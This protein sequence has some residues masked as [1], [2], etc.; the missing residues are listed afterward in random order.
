MFG[1][2]SPYHCVLLCCGGSETSDKCPSHAWRSSFPSS[3]VSFDSTDGR[4][5]CPLLTFG[6]PRANYCAC[7]V[8]L[9]VAH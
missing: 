9:I 1:G 6:V 3:L 7:V 4:L 8:F 5:N 2:L